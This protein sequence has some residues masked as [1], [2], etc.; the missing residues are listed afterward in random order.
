MFAS[1]SFREDKFVR[2]LLPKVFVAYSFSHCITQVKLESLIKKI[3]NY[4]QGQRVDFLVG[5]LNKF[6]VVEIDGDSHLNHQQKDQ[7][8]DQLNQEAG[9]STIRITNEEINRGS[10]SN[11]NKLIEMFKNDYQ[12]KKTSFN[13]NEK[14]LIALILQF[15]Y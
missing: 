3:D 2:E 7:L 4:N 11:I 5:S 12:T 1:D 9:L 15:N 10:G 14:Y 13:N 6:V 8:R